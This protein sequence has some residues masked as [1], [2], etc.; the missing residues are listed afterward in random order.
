ME[1]ISKIGL[2][3]FIL[4]VGKLITWNIKDFKGISQSQMEKFVFFMVIY[5][6]MFIGFGN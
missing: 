6:L 5:A 4:S 3:L 1:I 2:T